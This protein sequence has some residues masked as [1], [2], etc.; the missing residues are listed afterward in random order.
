MDVTSNVA[1]ETQP[2]TRFFVLRGKKVFGPF[3]QRQIENGK[4]E[5]KF[6]TTDKVSN[7]ANGPWLDITPAN[8]ESQNEGETGEQSPPEIVTSDV[9]TAEVVVAPQK[10]VS[11]DLTKLGPPPWKF[12][13]AGTGIAAA[14]CLCLV[15]FISW[16]F[17]DARDPSQTGDESLAVAAEDGSYQEEST[18]SG[19]AAGSADLDRVNQAL[20]EFNQAIADMRGDSNGSETDTS[21]SYAPP[22]NNDSYSELDANLLSLNPD[23]ACEQASAIIADTS[24]D[25]LRTA[26]LL[27]DKSART[28]HSR[29][30][31]LLALC[32]FAGW[33]VEVDEPAGRYWVEKAA[34]S[35]E[36]E[37]MY[38]FAAMINEGQYPE[39]GSEDCLYWL[40]RSADAGYEPAVA[41]MND[42]KQKQLNGLVGAV[43]LSAFGSGDSYSDDERDAQ[44]QNMREYM[45][46]RRDAEYRAERAAAR[47]DMEAY[48][49]EK[50]NMP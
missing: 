3:S 11:D 16:V 39:K 20:A 9:I 38:L 30:M 44:D 1:A 15:L 49:Y 50:Q 41:T 42:Y 2:P 19:L 47:G 5:G 27:L 10:P 13:A 45:M 17:S 22:V 21:G 23:E 25:A 34:N 35:G 37:A 12:I 14:V 40:G 4:R 28:G 26:Y 8:P 31:F 18:D 48:R 6:H 32:H 36:M 7:F 33:G 24:T 43:L 29:S 46:R